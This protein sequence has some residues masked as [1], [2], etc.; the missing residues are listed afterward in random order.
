MNMVLEELGVTSELLMNTVLHSA[1]KVEELNLKWL[2]NLKQ[3][4]PDLIEYKE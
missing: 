4:W 1:G 2:K 3:I